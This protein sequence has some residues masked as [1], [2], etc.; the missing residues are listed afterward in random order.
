[1]A[2]KWRICCCGEMLLNDEN[3][4]EKEELLCNL[5]SRLTS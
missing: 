4:E 2:L 3:D 5:T 1:M